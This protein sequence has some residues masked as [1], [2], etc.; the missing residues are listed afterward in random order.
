MVSLLGRPPALELS[1]SELFGEV[2][3]Y[4]LR[5]FLKRDEVMEEAPVSQGRGEQYDDHDDR[6]GTGFAFLAAPLFG[7]T[8]ATPVTLAAGGCGGVVILYLNGMVAACCSSQHPLDPELFHF[9][10]LRRAA[11]NAGGYG[12]GHA[13]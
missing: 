6:R 5:L 7:A 4:G 13:V 8:A 10:L 9:L 12:G 1:S 2:A 3:H 11:V